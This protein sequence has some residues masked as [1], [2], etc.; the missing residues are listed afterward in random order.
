MREDYVPL[1]DVSDTDGADSSHIRGS[2]RSNKS[3]SVTSSTQK[4]EV[5]S[6]PTAN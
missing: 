5:V 4:Y 6:R 1:I 3:Q 2:D